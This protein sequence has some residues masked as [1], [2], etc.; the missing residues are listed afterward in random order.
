MSDKLKA[1]AWSVIEKLAGW[2]SQDRANM[3]IDLI[4]NHQP[5]VC[6]EIGVFGGRSLIAMGMA[7]R[8]LEHGGYV[9]GIDP[10]SKEAACEGENEHNVDWWSN[11]CPLEQIYSDFIQ[12]I[13]NLK[14]TYE[15]RWI[16]AKAEEVVALYPDESINALSLDGNHSEL[17]STRE[18]AMWLPKMAPQSC[19][20]LDDTDW[21]TQAKA[22][23]MIRD[24]GFVA[25]KDTGKWIA[26]QKP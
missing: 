1:H 13:V 12:N 18:V 25:L 5:K 26:F 6:V 22:I 24:A 3:L 20:I 23:Q 21:V 4:L 15:C 14:L 19:L 7:L 8:H 10:W 9:T 17:A 2:C 16:R 11:K